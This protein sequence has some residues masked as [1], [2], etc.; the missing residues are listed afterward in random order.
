MDTAVGL[1]DRELLWAALYDG[2]IDQAKAVMITTCSPRS[3]T[4]RREELEL[5]AVGYAH[6]PPATNCAETAGP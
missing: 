4:P 1:C 6:T 3:P 5:I 2:R